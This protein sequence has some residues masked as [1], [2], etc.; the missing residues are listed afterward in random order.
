MQLGAEAGS[1]GVL[2]SGL[3]RWHCIPLALYDHF[4]YEPGRENFLA[5]TRLLQ[6]L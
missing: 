1:L 6:Q 2:L 4:V 3:L 5:E